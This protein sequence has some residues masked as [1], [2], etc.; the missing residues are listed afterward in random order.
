MPNDAID[1]AKAILVEIIRAGVEKRACGKQTV[2]AKLVDM[3]QPDLSRV[4]RGSVAGYSVWR[5]IRV[6]GALGYDVS[7]TFSESKER[8][9]TVTIISPAARF[10][11]EVKV[12]E[13]G[14]ATKTSEGHSTKTSQ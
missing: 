5:L 12:D 2:A 4:L 7:I 8:R 13:P 11:H 3:P 9:G 10:S 6:A 14:H 1:Q